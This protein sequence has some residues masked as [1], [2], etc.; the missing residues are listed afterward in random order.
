M[1]GG[2]RRPGVTPTS[3]AGP[4]SARLGRHRGV[5][6][7]QPPLPCVRARRT[8]IRH[9]SV[10]AGKEILRRGASPAQDA[11]P[12]SGSAPDPAGGRR[13]RGVGRTVIRSPH[14]P[15]SP[16]CA[17]APILMLPSADV[18]WVLPHVD[19]PPPLDEIAD[20]EVRPRAL[21]DM[22]LWLMAELAEAGIPARP[23]GH[24]RETPHAHIAVIAR[25]GG[26]D[27]LCD[28]GEDEADGEEPA[29][30]LPFGTPG[31]LFSC[32]VACAKSGAIGA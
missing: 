9:R 14:D 25:A 2:A 31:V 3:A 24:D 23:V 16:P 19:I 8:A 26:V 28:L 7:P 21:A 17:R 20:R 6:L 5:P 22:A 27:Y 1:K 11:H 10:E 29:A 18:H 32:R 15:T 12:P 4:A 13:S 30:E